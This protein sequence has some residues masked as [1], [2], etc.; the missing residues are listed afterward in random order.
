MLST[1][2]PP[3]ISPLTSDHPLA[4]PSVKRPITAEHRIQARPGVPNDML[5]NTPWSQTPQGRHQGR[6]DDKAHAAPPSLMQIEI[7]RILEE[8]AMAQHIQPET[9]RDTL[10]GTAE[11]SVLAMPEGVQPTEPD[12][13]NPGR[14]SGDTPSSPTMLG[15]E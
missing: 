11:N 1:V 4:L 9:R 6:T 12:T 5:S 2:F 7:S 10:P 3:A 13:G 14:E 8:Q 15:D